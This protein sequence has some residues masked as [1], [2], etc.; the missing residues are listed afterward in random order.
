MTR[1]D[2]LL[3]TL[4][5]A[6]A[7]P[8]AAAPSAALATDAVV[9]DTAGG[10]VKSE[11]VRSRVLFE[12]GATRTAALPGSTLKP[13]LLSA[14]LERKLLKPDERLACP[15]GFHLAGH[16]LQCTHVHPAPPFDAVEAL[17][18]SCNYWFA[19]MSRRL[20]AAG[21]L[22]V[23]RNFGLSAQL[24]PSVE[25]AGLQ[26]LGLS[27]VSASPTSLARAYAD[28]LHSGPHPVVAT[29]SP[30]ASSSPAKPAPPAAR[31]PVRASAGSPAGPFASRPALDNKQHSATASSS[32]SVSPAAP[33]A[34]KRRSRL[35]SW[36]NDGSTDTCADSLALP[37]GWRRHR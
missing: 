2:W 33:G 8:S 10:R 21:L 1:R 27:R 35:G 24:A 14:L 31:A 26:A 34:G 23:L 18:A 37:L 30:T 28:L 15:G 12:Q 7:G 19:T 25:Q 3:S 16:N 9:L 6:P 36:R 22:T 20:S 11:D 13:L 4:A 29:P 17:A 5:L 32:P